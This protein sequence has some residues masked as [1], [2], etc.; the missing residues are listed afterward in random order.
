MKVA[1]ESEPD[2]LIYLL[3]SYGMIF[4]LV[5]FRIVQSTGLSLTKLNAAI[6]DSHKSLIGGLTFRFQSHIPEF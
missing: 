1:N 2:I 3:K 5:T 4:C 6:N